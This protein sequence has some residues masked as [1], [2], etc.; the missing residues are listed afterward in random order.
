MLQITFGIKPK[1]LSLACK[2]LNALVY[3]SDFISYGYSSSVAYTLK[4]LKTTKFSLSLCHLHWVFSMNGKHPFQLLE[5]L[6]PWHSSHKFTFNFLGKH[7]PPKIVKITFDHHTSLNSHC[8]T[9]WS[10]FYWLVVGWVIGL[11]TTCI[12]T[13][14]PVHPSTLAILLSIHLSTHSS[15][16]LSI[17]PSLLFHLV[18]S[19]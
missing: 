1:I 19:T 11:L 9:I 17:Y 7:F 14:L 13:Q 10:F 18:T 5:W 12:S 2:A 15:I 4:F 8:N 6:A 16:H 3:L